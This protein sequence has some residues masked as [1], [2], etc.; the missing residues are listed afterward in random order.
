MHPRRGKLHK[1]AMALL[2]SA[3]PRKCK[4]DFRMSCCTTLTP[5]Q[6]SRNGPW[7]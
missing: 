7:R 2:T 6:G 4:Q 1:L 5:I 3:L